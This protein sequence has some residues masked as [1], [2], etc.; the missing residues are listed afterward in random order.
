MAYQFC[1][2]SACGR[3]RIGIGAGL[4]IQWGHPRGGSSPPARTTRTGP[5]HAEEETCTVKVDISH[6]EKNVALLHVEVETERIS[7]ARDSVY[8]RLVRRYNIP[9]F[10]KG[11]APPLILQRYVGKDAFDHEVLDDLLD[12]TY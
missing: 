12:A 10:R 6:P 4:R 3:S 11:K 8:R 2:C 7:Q 9:G 5:P 1:F